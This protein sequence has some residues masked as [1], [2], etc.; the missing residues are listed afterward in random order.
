MH[1]GFTRTCVG[2]CVSRYS[3]VC[4]SLPEADKCSHNCHQTCGYGEDT[5]C[6]H[7]CVSATCPN[8]Q[9]EC[10]DCIE[11]CAASK[12]VVQEVDDRSSDFEM[13]QLKAHFSES[14]IAVS[15]IHRGDSM[16]SG[17]RMAHTQNNTLSIS[18]SPRPLAAGPIRKP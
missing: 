14:F 17:F 7:K 5:V 3:N 9:D 2:E 15:V 1:Y 11:R 12:V 18:H 4:P 10:V 6:F 16:I 13:P 8:M